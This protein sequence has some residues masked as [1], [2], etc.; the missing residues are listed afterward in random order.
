LI[1]QF[2]EQPHLVS[3]LHPEYKSLPR[4]YGLIDYDVLIE[5]NGYKILIPW[6]FQYDGA[7]IPRLCWPIIG[8]PYLPEYMLPALGHDKVYH[9]H[10][11]ERHLADQML[12]D[13]LIL[14]GVSSFVAG[15][16]YRAVRTF[17]GWYWDNDDED[18]MYINK[19]I[20][21]II[22]SGRN[23]D[24]YHFRKAA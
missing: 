14:C 9:T 13:T 11:I 5:W 24:D 2:P 20:D 4:A 16:I 3:V 17:G 10:E 8:S 23:P 18:K 6:G 21:E 19:L 12:R 22:A 1:I 7:S 15:T